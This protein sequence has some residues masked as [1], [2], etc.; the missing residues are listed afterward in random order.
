MGIFCIEGIIL[1]SYMGIVKSRCKNPYQPIGIME[2]QQGFER[3]SIVG[4]YVKFPG[5]KVLDL[6]NPTGVFLDSRPCWMRNASSLMARIKVAVG[7][8]L[9]V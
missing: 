6:A 2:C 9:L 3:C 8:D 4:I 1:P 5:C 7:V